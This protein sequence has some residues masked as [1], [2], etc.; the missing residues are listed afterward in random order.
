MATP[1]H[2]QLAKFATDAIE[3]RDRAVMK[4]RARIAELEA[5]LAPFAR[6]A[7]S[8]EADPAAHV[9]ASKG[10]TIISAYDLRD[11]AVALRKR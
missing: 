7:G 8:Y 1:A 3:S 6:M 2:E 11:A 4:A 10:G 9:V 5:A